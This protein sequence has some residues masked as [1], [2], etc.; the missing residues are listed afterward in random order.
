[1][2]VVRWIKGYRLAVSRGVFKMAVKVGSSGVSVQN[3]RHPE[4]R[5]SEP[6]CGSHLSYGVLE[7]R[8][9]CL[10]AFEVGVETL[11]HHF[12]RPVVDAPEASQYGLCSS[13]CQRPHQAL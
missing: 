2:A 3:E 7:G 8:R 10:I 11:G 12:A 5:I 13:G 1:M 9:R 4:V 6:L